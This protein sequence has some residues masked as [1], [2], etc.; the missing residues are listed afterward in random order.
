MKNIIFVLVISI[1]SCLNIHAKVLEGAAATTQ[2]IALKN[3]SNSI[4]SNI[5]SEIIINKKVINKEYIKKINTNIA[6]SSNLPIL[7]V[8]FKEQIST[9]KEENNKIIAYLDSENC[10]LLYNDEIK[11]QSK[12][13]NRYL[14]RNISLFNISEKERFYKK[15]IRLID[16]ID[17]HKVVALALDQKV[18]PPLNNTK[19]QLIESL[20]KL[21]IT[22]SS[23]DEVGELLVHSFNLKGKSVIVSYPT[24]KDTKVTTEF[25]TKIKHNIKQYVNNNNNTY[26][27]YK[28]KG[29]YTIQSNGEIILKYILLDRYDKI[30]QEKE[31]KIPKYILKGI[32]LTPKNYCIKLSVRENGFGSKSWKKKLHKSLKN[33]KINYKKTCENANKFF[34]KLKHKKYFSDELADNVHSFKF[35]IKLLSSNG[36]LLSSRQFE[37]SYISE[38]LETFKNI[39]EYENESEE[40]FE[41]TFKNMINN[42]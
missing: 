32:S 34:I 11:K 40:F 35:Y 39:L 22:V 5:K 37:Q 9:K 6:V 1:I 3:L 38:N 29:K 10:L 2:I 41:E 30:T 21:K 17:R 8:N 24:Y 13:I 19:E 25:A 14:Q 23:L 7:G 27:S 42:R 36:T 26:L 20:E 16:N 33:S 31:I 15:A 18:F 12:L 4:K 28:L